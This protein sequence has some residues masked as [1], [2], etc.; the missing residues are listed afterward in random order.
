M[1]KFFMDLDDGDIGFSFGEFGVNSKGD[2]LMRV[3]DNMITNINTGEVHF[4]DSWDD[5]SD[6]SLDDDFGDS[7]DDDFGDS[8]DDD[9]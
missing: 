1:G 7:F 4:V 3:G 6:D 2:P 8:L 9:F 5:E